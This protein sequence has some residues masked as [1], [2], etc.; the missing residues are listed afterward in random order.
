MNKLL[1]KA[2][3]SLTITS[4]TAGLHTSDED[5]IKVTLKALYKNGIDLPPQDIEQW[6]LNNNWQK[7]PIKS[8]VKWASTIGTGGR[9]QLKF[10][11]S[12]PTEK[13]VWARLNA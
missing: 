9:V 7:Q 11:Q 5:T 2:L 6:L 10:K 4:N 8:V 3:D 1:I 12:A 13:E